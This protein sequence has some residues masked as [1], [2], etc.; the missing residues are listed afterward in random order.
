MKQI[1]IILLLAIGAFA[2]SDIK[3]DLNNT[4]TLNHN[5]SY[6][7]SDIFVGEVNVNTQLGVSL[8]IVNLDTDSPKLIGNLGSEKLHVIADSYNII[9]LIEPKGSGLVNFITYNKQTHVLYYTKQYSIGDGT[10]SYIYAGK[11][12]DYN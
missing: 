3:C 5:M 10:T 11:C 12:V 4:S 6:E 2:Q 9:Q 7:P 8:T 1:I